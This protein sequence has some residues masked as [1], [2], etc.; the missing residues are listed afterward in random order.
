M[1]LNLDSDFGS[2]EKGR[3]SRDIDEG[4]GESGRRFPGSGPG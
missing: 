2:E 3:G 1:G 4:K